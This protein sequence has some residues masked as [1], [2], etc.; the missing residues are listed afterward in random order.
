MNDNDQHLI[1]RMP[2]HALSPR[3]LQET[4]HSNHK[5][6]DKMVSYEQIRAWG[7]KVDKMW[8]AFGW[9]VLT[10]SNWKAI[11]IAIGLVT[12]IGGQDM[13]EVIAARLN[14]GLK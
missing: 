2:D 14:G 8:W 1:D 13:I 5:I 7:D 12:L 11:A 4:R 9:L 6:I 10:I 3:E